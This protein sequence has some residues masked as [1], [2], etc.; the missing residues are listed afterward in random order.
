MQ[1]YKIQE[2]KTKN[3]LNKF[4]KLPS[5]LYKDD[6]NWVPPIYLDEIEYFNPIKN[7]QWDGFERVLFLCLDQTG[8]VCGRIM[9]LIPK[10]KP[11]ILRFSLLETEHES[12]AIAKT[13]IDALLS[14]G[15]AF[16]LKE[17][18]GPLAL[19]DKDPQG[20]LIDG[21][22]YTPVIATNYN[23]P[24]RIDLMQALGFEKKIDLYVYRLNVLN[25]LPELYDKIVQRVHRNNS[26][27]R[28]LKMKSRWQLKKWI[29]PVFELVNLT[30]TEIY[31]F[32][33]LSEKE[34]RSLSYKYLPVL[35][36]KFLKIIVN[37][38]NDVIAFV[39]AMPNM[40]E[41]LRKSKGKMLPFGIFQIWKS[42]KKT[43]QLDM[44]LGAVHPKYQNRGLDA[45][46][47]KALFS[48]AKK[49]G[50]EYIDS[51]L[52]LETNIKMHA[53]NE[54][55]GGEKYKTYRIFKRSISI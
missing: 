54:K 17:L 35:N 15:S 8:K 11:E 22:E 28:L 2:V 5:H 13:L 14:W 52:E 26:D 40:T 30:F 27:L 20:Y 55:L 42:Q 39:L 49:A 23:T 24:K 38:N 31:A 37:A 32:S 7:P 29:V 44:L 46:L 4:I 16:D 10:G 41:G 51:H 21:F 18:V 33:P 36:P 53:E 45:V 47:A 25:Q 3:D 34:M 19:S 50:F 9:G 43:K 48:E 1:P 6:P 12:I